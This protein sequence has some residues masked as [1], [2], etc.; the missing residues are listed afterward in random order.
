MEVQ[1]DS[2][3]VRTSRKMVLEFLGSSVDIS[4]AGAAAPD[5]STAAYAARYGADP[6]RYG[7][8]RHRPPPA[9]ATRTSRA[10]T[11]PPP[12]TP[13]RRRSP[14][15]PRSTTTSTSA[16]TRNA[17][18][19]TSASRRAAT[20]PRTR[21][22][23]PS[24]VAGS[25]PGSRPSRPSAARV[26]LRLLRQLHRRL[27]DRRADGQARVRHAR[28][29]YLGPLAADRDRDHL[30]VLRRRLRRRAPRPGRADPQGDLAAGLIGHRRPPVREGP[31]RLRVRQRAAAQARSHGRW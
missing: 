29:G 23:S 21:S 24:R 11:T 20:T 14:S 2:E 26:G 5:G 13:R 28:G 10:T 3:R 15:R 7:R 30:P 22:R 25:T 19:A 27:P 18:S 9:S 1:T 16:T 6:T 17:S 31:L 8:R 4:L 12:A